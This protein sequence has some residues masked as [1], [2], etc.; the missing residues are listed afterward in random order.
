M[1]HILSI[2][3]MSFTSKNGEVIL[4]KDIHYMKSIFGEQTFYY[5]NIGEDIFRGFIQNCTTINEPKH[6]K[7]SLT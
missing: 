2:P 7:G 1:S 4:Y 5:G 3:F 6:F